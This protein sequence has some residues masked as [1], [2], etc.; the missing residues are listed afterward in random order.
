MS[1]HIHLIAVP[2]NATALAE[3]MQRVHGRYA[4]YL[5][6]RRGRCERLWQNRY[7][8]C[9]LGP[10]H[11]WAAL[12]YVELNP[13]RARLVATPREYAWSS[14]EAHCS[15]QDP[16]RIADMRFWS[17]SGGVEGWQALLSQA[18][19]E[20]DAKALRRATYSGQPLGDEEF[21][22]TLRAQRENTRA[23][24]HQTRLLPS[25]EALAFAAY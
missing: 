24:R 13:V 10:K 6:A 8:S 17:E 4:Q 16:W 14:A 15:G 25:E 3:F 21:V 2:E 19:D 9:A 23:G 22:E 20:A 12:R 7:N 5:N 1:N 11:L 18:D